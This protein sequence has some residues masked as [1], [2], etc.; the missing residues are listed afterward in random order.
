MENVR[1]NMCLKLG[2]YNENHT[3]IVEKEACGSSE[4]CSD[5]DFTV[6]RLLITE[7]CS[8]CFQ[9]IRKRSDNLL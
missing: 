8:E 6:T 5:T 1:N 2:Y 3:E 7:H 9:N 4:D